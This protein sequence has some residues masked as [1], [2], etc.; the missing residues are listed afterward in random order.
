MNIFLAATQDLCF[1]LLY[2]YHLIKPQQPPFY[3]CYIMLMISTAFCC[4]QCKSH[5]PLDIST[6]KLH[7]C[8]L[9]LVTQPKRGFCLS[10]AKNK[11]NTVFV[12]IYMWCCKPIYVSGNYEYG[13]MPNQTRSKFKEGISTNLLLFCLIFYV[14]IKNGRICIQLLWASRCCQWLR[15]Q[16]LVFSFC[17]LRS[18]ICRSCHAL[19]CF[20]S[21]TNLCLSVP[22]L[23]KLNVT[24]SQKITYYTTSTWK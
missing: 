4:T 6:E 16:G 12:C 9:F 17:P 19:L 5:S 3:A 23:S 22:G 2:F 7:K 18:C 24:H 11:L 10:P 15:L 8:M 21:A 20:A 14:G 13:Y 1:L